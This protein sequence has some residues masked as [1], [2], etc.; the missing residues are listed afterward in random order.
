MPID[1]I[2][3]TVGIPTTPIPGRLRSVA[4]VGGVAEAGEIIDDSM[5]ASQSQINSEVK[6]K[7]EALEEAIQ[8]AYTPIEVEDH[9]STTS[10]KP[11]QN[12]VISN[13]LNS[14]VGT[15]DIDSILTTKIGEQNLVN[16]NYLSSNYYN[17]NHIDTNFATKQEISSIVRSEIDPIFTGSP[18]SQITTQDITNWNS[19]P[20]WAK[21]STKPTYTASEVGALPANYTPPVT[22]VNN[23]TGAV[24]LSIPTTQDIQAAITVN[25]YTIADSTPIA[26]INGV[27]ISAP[28]AGATTITTVQSDWNVTDTTS[29]AY[30]VNRPNLAAVATSGSYNDLSN[31]PTI[32]TMPTWSTLS[33]KPTLAAVATSGSYNDL[34]NTPTIPTATSDL[35]NDSGFLTSH[36][37]ISS[38]ANIADLAT[39]ATSGN[40]NDLSNKPNLLNY[41]D[42]RY[43]GTLHGELL[44][45]NTE[46]LEENADS[47]LGILYNGRNSDALRVQDISYGEYYYFNFPNKSGTIA[48][49]DAPA[50]TGIPTAPTAAVGT[51][52]TQI[53]TTA[54]V[55]TAI[56]NAEFDSSISPEDI[57]P[58]IEDY[59]SNH[60]PTSLFKII[61]QNDAYE[62]VRGFNSLV[63]NF[64]YLNFVAVRYNNKCYNLSQ[65]VAPDDTTVNA[66]VFTSTELNNN[67]ITCDKFTI[68]KDTSDSSGCIVTRSTETLTLAFNSSTSTLDISSS[69]S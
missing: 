32:P 52:T 46:L 15:N 2:D 44:I 47:A 49:T 34:S 18:A 48:L 45:D 60:L 19:V 61:Y 36:Q 23:Q 65:I 21:N 27:E 67:V 28:T 39:V 12:K 3:R 16:S 58:I 4:T 37:D 55:K 64:Q 22:S 24:S 40:Y 1:N 59:I 66:M 68:T 13:A 17:K 31:K 9:L 41:L 53:A 14:K 38:K 42:T 35:T 56:A 43:G 57:D 25:P 20:A 54:F 10:T 29:G 51:N 8:G 5:Q 62:L 6:N 26:T 11:V 7:I 50:F 63:A 33:G 30:I 69:Q